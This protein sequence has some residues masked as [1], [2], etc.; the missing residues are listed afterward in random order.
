MILMMNKEKF[1]KS[2]QHIGT[3]KFTTETYK[4][5]IEFK[6]TWNK[7]NFTM[8][9]RMIPISNKIP[10]D[11][12]IFIL[13]M[14]NETNKIEGIGIIK[15]MPVKSEEVGIRIYNDDYYNTYL[16]YGKYHISRNKILENKDNIKCLHYLE[17]LVFK[18]S[19][20]LKRGW[21]TGCFSLKNERIE[22][23]P[24]YNEFIV[25]KENWKLKN[26]YKSVF[27]ALQMDLL[28][29]DKDEWKWKNKKKAIRRCSHCH[30]L[31]NKEHSEKNEKKNGKKWKK[32]SLTPL[33]CYNPHKCDSCGQIK[34]GHICPNKKKHPNNVKI[35]YKF[36]RGLF[37]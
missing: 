5:N 34:H 14:N 27:E 6:K 32:C 23:S 36:L 31:K 1:I 33:K 9:T 13:E 4:E 16:Y 12:G 2:I 10:A 35:V 20:H 11:V 8:A 7:S 24:C 26:I 25:D 30:R 29:V 37:I 22:T 17:N 21:N 3:S 28:V 19:H 18:G 15:N